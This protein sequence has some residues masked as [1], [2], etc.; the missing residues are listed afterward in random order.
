M[1]KQDKVISEFCRKCGAKLSPE[2]KF[3]DCCG[4]STEVDL[5]STDYEN[6]CG[7]CTG[8][9]EPEDQYCRYCGTKR[10][11]GEFNPYYDEPVCVYGPPPVNRLHTCK[12]CGYEWTV[13]AMIDE[14]RY[15]P[16]CGHKCKTKILN[17][18][19]QRRGR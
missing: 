6:R 16:K 10:G 18:P 2:S 17:D 5:Y 9:L 8:Y 4:T 19:F 13:C 11:E 15:C 1:K 14:Q 3:C 12:K 7:K